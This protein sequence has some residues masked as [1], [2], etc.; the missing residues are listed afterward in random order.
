M[1][2]EDL[3][4]NAEGT[5][6]QV[7]DTRAL[8]IAVHVAVLFFGQRLDH[9]GDGQILLLFDQAVKR[10]RWDGRVS[11]AVKASAQNFVTERQGDKARNG[12]L[13]LNKANPFVVLLFNAH[14][15]RVRTDFL[16]ED[17]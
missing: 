16:V 4:G 12:G 15:N 5:G 13:D 11:V 14:L 9:Q 7:L 1:E 6:I 3:V 8:C 17:I 10:E 2:A